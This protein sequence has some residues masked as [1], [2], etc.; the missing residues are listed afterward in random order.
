MYHAVLGEALS[1]QL[2]SLRVIVTAGENLPLELVRRHYQRLPQATLYN[3]YGPTE[4]TVWCSVYQ[5]TREEAGARIPIGTPIAHMQ[6]YVLDARLQPMPI[7]VPGELYVAGACLARGYV[8]QPQLTHERFVANPYVTGTRLYRT[9]DLARS[10]ADGNVEF[11]GRVDHQVKLRG[12]R[13]ELGEI[14]SVLRDVPGVQHAAVLLRQDT[15]DQPR[16]VGYV[17]GEPSLRERLDQ[18][19]SHLAARLPS[20]MVPAV[21]L[22]LD[23]MPLSAGGKVNRSALPAPDQTDGRAAAR[24]A[25]R[26]PVEASLAELWKSV[27][28]VPE[29]GIHD[30]FFE[31]GGH[32]LVATQLV[33]RI[34]ELFE[35][36]VSLQALFERPTIAALADE[37]LRLRQ[38]ERQAALMPPIMPVPRE[39]PLPLSYSQQRMWLMHRLAPKSTAYHM[40]FASRQMGRLNKTALRSTID[41]ICRR[42]EAFR[43]TFTM[44]GEGP[45]QLISPFRAPHWVEV[46]LTPFPREQRQ[47]EAMRLVAEESNQPFD[48]EKGPLARF[49][50]IE[51]EPEDH[52][53]ML[54]MHHIIGDQWSFGVIGA[55]FAF[56]YNALCRGEAPTPQPI[57]LQ[58]ADYAVWQ[59]RC[60]TDEWLRTQADYWQTKLAGLSKLSLPTDYP[61]PVVQTFNGAHR[62]LE[63]PTSLI[64]RLQHFSAD[65]HAT[66]FMTLL[67]CF[68][69]LLSRYAGQADVAVGTPIANR[70]QSAV[71]SIIGSFVN[72]LV[73]RTDLS[74][75]PTFIEL[76]ARVRATAL[77]AYAHQDFPFDKLVET[78][79]SARDQ[80]SAP[81]VQVLFNVPN[82][83]I[84]E[85]TVQG[86]SW[87]PFEVETQAAQFDLSLTIETEFSRKAYLTFNTDLFEPQTAERMLG[88]YKLLLQSALA[89]PDRQVIRA[90]DRDGAR[91]ATDGAGLEPHATRLSPVSM[92]SAAV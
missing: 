1:A 28:H 3:E 66:V 81:L 11:L 64:E 71:E 55:E 85:I 20:Y 68:Q 77:A 49:V 23:T 56:F 61:R 67:A 65:H 73:L 5:T 30:Q 33:S 74:G 75:N 31:Q 46:D 8:N 91:A 48:L 19:R 87:V 41:A 27:L 83:P 88:Q 47:R 51:I 15:L 78:M 70:T 84:G 60:L 76:L 82:A 22:W 14:E 62:L 25:P 86:L 9:G 50:L 90:S 26:N 13:I 4:A 40:P 69:I 63:L 38:R 36:E 6:L 39:Q 57:P 34:R 52:I 35:V 54:T 12:Y 43:T 7:G 72:T 18:V 29:A 2:D 53:L 42:H 10:R 89:N 32:S 92:F 24:I 37:V 17:A 45:V 44:T 80:S 16:L 21:L 79:H 59:R 58:Y